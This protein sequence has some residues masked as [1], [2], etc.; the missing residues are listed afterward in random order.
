MSSCG[1]GIVFVFLSVCLGVVGGAHGLDMGLGGSKRR[2]GGLGCREVRLGVFFCCGS[3]RVRVCIFSFGGFFVFRV[4]RVLG[5]LALGMCVG[6]LEWLPRREA[7]VGLG[8]GG[9]QALCHYC[10]WLVLWVLGR[11]EGECS[12]RVCT[13]EGLVFIRWLSPE[14]HC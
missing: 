7:C 5:S 10:G 11:R 12:L 3:L 2:N 8:F 1:V 14:I 6:D 13:G 9:A 4:L